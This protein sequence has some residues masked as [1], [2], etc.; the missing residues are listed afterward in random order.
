[1][2][3]KKITEL[4]ELT[5]AL[6][7]DVIPIVDIGG[8]ETK[9]ITKANLLKNIKVATSAVGSPVAG[10]CYFNATTFVFYIYTGA[11]WKSIQLI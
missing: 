2:A 10:D 7:V 3:D 9:K 5:D 1:M 11:A 8:N 4:V 6:D